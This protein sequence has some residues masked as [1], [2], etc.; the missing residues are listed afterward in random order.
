MGFGFSSTRKRYET[1]VN[2]YAC[3]PGDRGTRNTGLE[4]VVSAVV[5]DGTADDGFNADL[6]MRRMVQNVTSYLTR[7]YGG[8]S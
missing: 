8:A 2:S 7:M 3:I 5:H 1:V 6:K 4:F